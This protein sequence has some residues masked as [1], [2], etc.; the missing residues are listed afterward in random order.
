MAS[1]VWSETDLPVRPGFYMN[2]KAAA[3]AAIAPG[4]RGIVAM[5]VKA[6]WGPKETIV[7]ITSEKELIDA[8]NTETSGSLTA[9]K[10]GRLALLGQPQ[11]LLL[12][13]LADGSA[14]KAAITLKDGAATDV[15]TLTTKYDTTRAFKITV[16]D[17]L[18]DAENKKDIVL[19]EGT[20]QLYVFTFAK[21][22]GIV[23]NAVA[24][25]N[26][27]TQNAW[28]TAASVAAGNGTLA[29]IT[30]QSLAGGN[31][32]TAGIVN[33]DYIDAMAAFEARQI[34][35]FVLDGATDSSL[36]TSVIVWVER[37][38]DEGKKIIAYIGGTTS[39]DASIATGNSR[40]TTTNSE[41]VVNVGVSGILDGVTYSSA[42]VACYIAGKASGQALKESL[43]YASTVFDDVSPR[44]T[45]NQVV[46]AIK[47][48]TLVLVHDG[49][50]V[51]V[52]KGI[53][54]LTSLGTDQ[55]NQW[56][57]I[58]LIRIMDA[59]A[60]D[61]AKAA[62]DNYIGK[63]LNNEDG[64]VA[65][66][67]AIKNYFE[68]LSPDLIAPG[69]IVEVDTEKQATAE[70]DQF[71]WKYSATLVDSMEQIFGTGYIS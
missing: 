10:C 24:A 6:N 31:D 51:I 15:L 5:P 62:Q 44:L 53:N 4:P 60:M 19:F 39:D 29:D 45:H 26:N 57:K 65:V 9:Y 36:Q 64:Q 35:A 41:G 38:R 42:Q 22:T 37:L 25:I 27:D 30:T 71:F 32:G 61:T 54:T 21:G 46:S 12:Y 52:E 58:K 68:T 16:R 3:L 34:N 47:A 7:E 59:I 13:R 28:I 48:G 63:V 17:S 50:K 2:F 14:A 67:N 43:T 11:T 8:F 23:D 40:S 33:Q 55:G 1:G 20:T 66:L 70:N 69:F 18:V 56:K 49:E